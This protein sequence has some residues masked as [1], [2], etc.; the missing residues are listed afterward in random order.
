MKK[1][2]RQIALVIT[3]L[4]MNITLFAQ[5]NRLLT[6]NF[7]VHSITCSDLNDGF[8]EIF[9]SGG[10]APYT[11]TWSTGAVSNLIVDLGPGNYDATIEDAAG[12]SISLSIQMVAPAPITV[13]AQVT[14]VTSIGGSDGEIDLTVSGGSGNIDMLWNTGATTSMI[15]NLTTGSY[16]VT[17]TD[18]NGCMTTESIVVGTSL[19]PIRDNIFN[20]FSVNPN[21]DPTQIGTVYPNPSSGNVNFRFDEELIQRIRLYRSNGE[22]VKDMNAQSWRNTYLEKGTYYVHYISQ[23][24]IEK[25]DVLIVK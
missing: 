22:L 15:Q 23:E 24:K 21:N 11:V 3:V 4:L 19:T 17:V 14:D 12:L 13:S 8:I 18:E 6:A 7:R 5:N 20:G 9:P 1:N 25:R 2:V 10:T 16:D